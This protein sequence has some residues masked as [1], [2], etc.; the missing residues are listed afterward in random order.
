[1][2]EGVLL[3]NSS[4]AP[5]TPSVQLIAN[6]R[7]MDGIIAARVHSTSYFSADYFELTLALDSD[8]LFWVEA[9]PVDVD[10]RL[11]PDASDNYVSVLQGRVD[12]LRLDA[13][14]RLARLEGRDY[15]SSL[16]DS[17]VSETFSNRT[18]S[19]IVTLLAQRHG[20]QPA[21]VPT[22]ETIGR[23]YQD[24]RD[25]VMLDAFSGRASEWDLLAYLAQH[26]GY[27]LFVSGTTLNFLPASA[28]PASSC[29]LTPA[30]VIELRLE[31]NLP[32]D[33]DVTIAVKTWNSRLHAADVRVATR[34]G[35]ATPRNIG[36]P[37]CEGRNYI[38][39]RPNLTSDAAQRLAERRLAEVCTHGSSIDLTMPGE[40][41]L[42]P[43]S[44]FVLT[45]TGTDFD[46]PYR[47]DVV[48]RRISSHSGFMQRIRASSIP[49]S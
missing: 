5:R 20:L 21:V 44:V 25:A 8:R 6:G 13:L 19:E 31:R 26:E 43:R 10:V 2:L 17:V 46:R 39:I 47:I 22:T 28:P 29:V 7:Q 11:R 30:D 48:D 33:G 41:T 9:T 15:A 24:G 16:I 18:A 35:G 38:L 23:Y 3:I 4:G 36:V 49:T 1:M 14:A 27:D 12:A 34:I 37:T 45:G 32:F 40:M 42:M